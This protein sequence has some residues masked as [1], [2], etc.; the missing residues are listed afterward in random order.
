MTTVR[1]K[2][3]LRSAISASNSEAAIGSSP[4]VGSSRKRM[5]GSSASARAS[6][7]RL[8]M[9]PESSAGY[10]APSSSFSPTSSTFS[11]DK[12]AHQPA[13]QV[14]ELAHRDLDVLRRRSARRTARRTGR[15]RPSASPSPASG[16]PARSSRRTP[17]S[18]PACGCT[19]PRIERI[20]TDL[21]VPDAP[22]MAR[23]SPRRTSTSRFSSTVVPPKPTVRPRTWM[24]GSPAAVRR[25]QKS[26]AP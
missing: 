7:A 15:A 14:E 9:P 6:A 13:R 16:R 20:S 10:L 24:I 1:P 18:R 4:A 2:V 12:R 26:I 19:R 21:P 8:I 25:H 11:R 17:R 5:S 22:T 3:F 23:I